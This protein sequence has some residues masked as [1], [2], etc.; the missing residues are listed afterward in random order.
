MGVCVR[1][2]L[3]IGQKKAPDLL[4]PCTCEVLGVG[5]GNWTVVLCCSISALNHWAIFPALIGSTLPLHLTIRVLIHSLRPPSV[6]VSP[7]LSLKRAIWRCR[8]CMLRT[9]VVIALSF[10]VVGKDHGG[11]SNA[12]VPWPWIQACYCPIVQ[13]ASGVHGQ[14]HAQRCWRRWGGKVI[15][16]WIS[17]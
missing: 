4:D 2:C 16:A 3:H 14:R 12:G 9:G 15:A 6:S 13:P 5:D 1:G 11:C 8:E 7:Q 17:S 10:T